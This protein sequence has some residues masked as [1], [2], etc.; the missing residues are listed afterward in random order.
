MTNLFATLV[1]LRQPEP[2]EG[3]KMLV[4]GTGP[5]G[6]DGL[7]FAVGT[8]VFQFNSNQSPGAQKLSGILGAWVD[9]SNLT[10]GKNL[11]LQTAT[12][13]FVIAGGSQAYVVF[14]STMPFSLSISSGG[15]TGTVTVILYNYN[16]LFTGTVAG[17]PVGASGTGGSSG[18]GSGGTGYQ[19]GGGGGGKLTL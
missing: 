6:G 15:G 11:V 8:E 2:P 7:N 14:T 4:L 17:A 9:A 5:G 19:G 16:P 10:A 1:G 13:K 3:R 18:G 12:Q